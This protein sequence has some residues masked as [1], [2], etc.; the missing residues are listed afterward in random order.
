M[1]TKT[2][3][4]ASTGSKKREV[5]LERIFRAPIE[6]VWELWTTKDGIES[7]WG[8]DGFRVTVQTLDLRVGGE[9]HYTMTAIGAEQIKA[10]EQAGMPAANRHRVT[11]TKVV[12]EKRLDYLH[13]VDF[14][15]SK[16]PYDLAHSVE[17]FQGPDG[18]RMVLSFE[19]MHDAF[20]TQMAKAGWENELDKLGTALASRA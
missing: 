1:N 2:E 4:E 9:L 7:W 8:P 19:A 14:I 3:S 6:D 10:V 18:V 15:P 13:R 12:P 20:W 11:F 5:T 17:L 16:E